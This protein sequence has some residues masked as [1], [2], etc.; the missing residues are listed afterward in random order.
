M[1]LWV[2]IVGF[3]SKSKAQETAVFVYSFTSSLFLGTVFGPWASTP[4]IFPNGS[5]LVKRPAISKP[6]EK[7]LT[8]GKVSAHLLK[9]QEFEEL[10]IFTMEDMQIHRKNTNMG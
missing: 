5:C 7:L 8:P 10:H 1:D 2:A 3:G 6:D 9:C 4:P